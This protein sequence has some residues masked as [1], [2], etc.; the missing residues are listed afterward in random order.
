MRRPFT[1]IGALLLLVVAAAHVYRAV[2]GIDAAIGNE[3]VPMVVSWGAAAIF[4]IA[5]LMT[6]LELRK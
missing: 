4:G 1:L 6:L 2:Q 3:M 5:G